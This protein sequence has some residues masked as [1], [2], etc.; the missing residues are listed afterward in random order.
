M[1][2]RP[3]LYM[4]LRTL[5]RVGSQ[6]YARKQ[7]KSAICDRNWG[8]GIG[9]S[10]APLA[11]LRGQ[12]SEPPTPLTSTARHEDTCLLGER[13]DRGCGHLRPWEPF[14]ERGPRLES[15][16]MSKRGSAA[17]SCWIAAGRPASI[18]CQPLL[19]AGLVLGVLAVGWPYTSGREGRARPSRRCW[20]TKP[21]ARSRAPTPSKSSPTKRRPNGLTGLPNRRTW[22]THIA[23]IASDREAP[24]IAILDLDQFKEFND[25]HGHPAGDPSKRPP[26]HGA[27]SC[28]PATFS[29]ASAEKNSGCCFPTAISRLL[30]KSSIG[31]GDRSRSSAPAQHD[32]PCEAPANAPR[33]PSPA[34]TKPLPS[35]KHKDETA[36][37]SHTPRMHPRV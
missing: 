5:V 2:F 27:T 12:H 25:T 32:S 24:A 29:L 18:L 3:S 6:L 20:L 21:P 35:K 28:A 11:S 14:A 19:K 26:P 4:R 34:P 16:R 31:Y 23:R 8:V 10:A 17:A 33:T 15:P 37:T 9:T 22:E 1:R 7:R 30:L 36:S 13:L